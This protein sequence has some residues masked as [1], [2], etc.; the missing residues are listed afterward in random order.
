VTPSRPAV[1]RPR[2]RRGEGDQTREA[3]VEAADRLLASSPSF[4]GVSV[5]AVADEVG[6]TPA[7][8]YRHFPDKESLLFEACARHFD[9]LVDE[10]AVPALASTDDPVEALRR[11]AVAYVRFGVEHPEHY[12]IMFLGPEDHAPEKYAAEQVLETGLFGLVLPVVQRCL[13]EGLIRADAGDALMVAWVLWM[14]VHGITSVAVAKPNFPAPP[15]DDQ[16]TAVIDALFRG[17]LA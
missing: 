13:D 11:L 7:A 8:I 12:R 16:L 3:I 6:L 4:A 1:A 2:A 14:G 9:D 10:F 17:L 5:R 15:L